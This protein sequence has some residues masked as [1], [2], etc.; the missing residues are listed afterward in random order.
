AI[1]DE[2]KDINRDELIKRIVSLEFNRFIEYY[3]E[4][5]DLNIDFLKKDH[6]RAKGSNRKRNSMFINL[7]TMDGFNTD[8]M[9]DYLK[10]MTG[11]SAEAFERIN[12]K[13]AY[14]F[15]DMKDPFLPEVLDSFENEVYKG[16]KIRVDGS[17]GGGTKTRRPNSFSGRKKRFYKKPS[18]KK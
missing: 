9:Q 8:S 11:L 1:Y 14:S 12:I 2:L 17:G 3:R 5:E 7:G 18:W 6:I 13:G 10:E 16:R 4:E 15:I